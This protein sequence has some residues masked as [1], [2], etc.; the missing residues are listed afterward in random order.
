M[1]VDDFV[2]AYIRCEGGATLALEVSWASHHDHPAQMIMALYGTEGGVVRR[3]ENYVDAPLEVHRREDGN[4]ATPKLLSLDK[5]GSVQADFIT[6]VREG[7]EPA[8]S[9][10]HG[11]AAM[12]II[13]AIYE[14]SRTGREVRLKDLRH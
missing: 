3:P 8:C 7:H 10:A 1:N 6:A 4:L 12:R 13:D 14:S 2:S 11:L 5:A 9:G